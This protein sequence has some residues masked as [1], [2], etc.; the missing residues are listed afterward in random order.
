M[1]KRTISFTL[2]L[3]AL[4]V[5]FPLSGI[6][7]ADTLHRPQAQGAGL[8]QIDFLGDGPGTFSI[9]EPLLFLVKTYEDDQ[10]VFRIVDPP[11]YEAVRRERV[12]SIDQDPG[13]IRLFHESRSYGA[14][15]AGCQV[16]FVQIEDN[17]DSRRN[18]FFINGDLVHTVEQGMVTYGSFVAPAAGELTFYAE[19]SVGLVVLPCQVIVTG[20]PPTPPPPATPAATATFTATATLTVPATLTSTPT[21]TATVTVPPPATPTATASATVKRTNTTAPTNPNQPSTTPSLTPTRT[22]TPLSTSLSQATAR[23]ATQAATPAGIP[24]TGGGPGPGDIGRAGAALAG[25]LGLVALGWV[26]LIRWY[27]R[28]G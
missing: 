5:L 3:L 9:E 23:T 28:H 12:W 20:T 21:A 6:A 10:F 27:R 14:V 18:S 2:L 1:N 19:D 24:V 17:V 7:I 11:T 26:Q 22:R 25:A 15:E 8:P 16:D 13:N 4:A